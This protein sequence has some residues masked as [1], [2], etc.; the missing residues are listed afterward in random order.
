[1]SNGSCTEVAAPRLFLAA[2]TGR[3]QLLLPGLLLA[4]AVA[5][6]AQLL[7]G[8]IGGP[9][10]VYA[11][12]LGMV[13]ACLGE[14]PRCSEGIGYAARSV[15]RLGVALL[16]LQLSVATLAA[17]GPAT[18]ATIFLLVAFSVGLGLFIGRLLGFED[19]LAL[20]AACATSICGAS[21]AMAVAAALPRGEQLHAQKCMIIA[22]IALLS[23]G[24]MLA[25]PLL[26]HAFGLDPRAAGFVLGA[27]IHDV[28]QVVSA[29]YAMSGATG[30]VATLVKLSRITCL[31]PMI[32]LLGFCYRLHPLAEGASR[33]PLVPGFMLAF[34]ALL[35]LNSLLSLPPLLVQGAAS[36]SR[37]CL[38]MAIAALGM[39]TS[40][41]RMSMLGGRLVA[42]LCVHALLLFCLAL[43]AAH[44]LRL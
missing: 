19:Q 25:Y 29:G 8:K 44:A 15:L 13:V 24:A 14:V 31:L 5:L 42:L 33:P 23:T 4:G 32:G 27:S 2:L 17:L 40:L 6:A 34:G 11:L 21:A 1:M 20:L 22:T 35:A 12:F 28:A 26:L 41:R 10:M 36:L 18:L 38:V 3:A 39:Q 37:F 9:A 43:M 7:A 30:D 16:G